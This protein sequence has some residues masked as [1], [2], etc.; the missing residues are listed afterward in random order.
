M[1]EHEM[2]VVSLPETE[3]LEP[4]K[5]QRHHNDDTDDDVSDLSDNDSHA[6]GRDFVPSSMPQQS[7]I[8]NITKCFH[9]SMVPG[10]LQAAPPTCTAL[11][12]LLVL[13]NTTSMNSLTAGSENDDTPRL[14]SRNKISSAPTQVMKRYEEHKRSMNN[15]RWDEPLQ[16]SASTGL[17][18]NLLMSRFHPSKS[19]VGKS[20]T[21]LKQDR[22]RSKT[23]QTS[24]VSRELRTDV[25]RRPP[26]RTDLR[27]NSAWAAIGPD[28]AAYAH[29]RNA[30]WSNVTTNGTPKAPACSEIRNN[31]V[32]RVRSQAMEATPKQQEHTF[33]GIPR[34]VC[35]PMSDSAP[36]RPHRRAS[37][38]GGDGQFQGGIMHQGSRCFFTP[39]ID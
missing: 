24:I 16:P 21:N 5:P 8:D 32:L 7:R 37:N 20:S 18:S 29:H 13:K 28:H 23:S 38:G 35:T 22:L 2:K 6:D 31:F 25:T 19:I 39:D 3:Y 30:T 4:T 15:A 11:K 34:L 17:S 26:S 10:G 1:F 12:H 14:P 27:S 36:C 33:S 9:P